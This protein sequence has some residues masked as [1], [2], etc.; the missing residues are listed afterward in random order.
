MRYAFARPAE[1]T[2]ERSRFLV[3]AEVT[4]AELAHRMAYA[5]PR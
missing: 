4:A 1:P 2:F 3:V 5:W